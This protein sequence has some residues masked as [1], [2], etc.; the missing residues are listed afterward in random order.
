MLLQEREIIVVLVC[1]GFYLQLILRSLRSCITLL[2]REIPVTV[3]AHCLTSFSSG[4][5]CRWTTDTPLCVKHC[6]GDLVHG[7]RGE[8]VYHGR[9][10]QAL[11]QSGGGRP[12]KQDELVG[13][14]H[15]VWLCRWGPLD[16]D[17]GGIH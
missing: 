14:D 5:I 16:E 1:V 15:P 8:V 10:G 3:H 12:V 7:E 6:D 13:L 9:R 2:N 17:C 11:L 4:D